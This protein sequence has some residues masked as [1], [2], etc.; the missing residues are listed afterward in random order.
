MSDTDQSSTRTDDRTHERPDG[1]PRRDLL[2]TTGAAGLVAGVG[3][4][5][6]SR[7]GRQDQQPEVGLDV[8][9]KQDPGNL[10]YWVPP[11]K[12]RLSEQVFGTPEHPKALVE[13]EINRAEREPI[14]Q[15]LRDFPILVGVP[16]DQRETN[17]DGTAFTTTAFPTPFPDEGE[18]VT[19]QLDVTYRDR[20]PY[21]IPGNPTETPDDAD[22]STTFTDPDGHT[23]ELRF[24][25]AF[26]PPIPGYQTAGGVM[27]NAWHHGTTGTGTPLMPMVYTYGAFWGIG[28][29]VIDDEV[30]DRNKVMHFMT[31]Q[32]VRTEEY[33][34]ATEEILPLAPDQTIAGQIHHT[35]GIVL[36][37]KITEQGVP[38]FEPV[39]TDYIL[40]NGDQQTFIHVMFEEDTVV[41]A[42]FKGWEY[43]TA[44]TP[45]PSPT[46]SPTP[47]Q[48][49]DFRL[50]GRTSAWIG[51]V[52]QSI[53][54]E[55]NPSLPLTPGTE[56]TLVWRNLDG[57]T[58]N[59]AI[60]DGDGNVVHRTE[61]M[62]EE[63]DTQTTTFTASEQMEEYLC[64]VHPT[65]MRG[66]VE[67]QS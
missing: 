35:H 36:P 50:G 25:T 56:Y 40:P 5:A 23:Y 13:P 24:K 43:P 66:E 48:R 45:T 65:T 22:L 55:E 3:G 67:I 14:K 6:L 15:L 59:F 49:A 1:V 18:V 44:A 53:D 19:G 64:Q 28:D 32:T 29:V 60:L 21:D 38:Q 37:V 16:P 10:V 39:N 4:L 34:L 20:R 47:G 33:A 12:R 61:F 42:P 31:T 52:P 9:V 57:A 54:G 41:E 27:T 30:G 26:Q 8:H 62:S 46:P 58:H 63:G 2:R 11:G 51:R 17:E 7:R